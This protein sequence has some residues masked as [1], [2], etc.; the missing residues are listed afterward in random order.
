MPHPFEGFQSATAKYHGENA[1]ALSQA[2]RLAYNE[3]AESAAFA[4]E[5]GFPRFRFID[6][7]ETQCLVIANSSAIVAAF[8]GTEPG[9]LKDWMNDLDAQFC[10]GCFGEVHNVTLCEKNRAANPF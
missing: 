3:A 1:V 7:R 4:A 6:R 8:R 5:W 2:S 10:P 9:K